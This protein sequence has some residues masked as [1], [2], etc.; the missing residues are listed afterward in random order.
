MRSGEATAPETPGSG[1]VAD[2]LDDTEVAVVLRHL[3]PEAANGSGDPGRMRDA[4]RAA[5]EERERAGEPELYPLSYNQ[6]SLWYMRQLAPTSAAYNVAAV[7]RL[8]A[9]LDV[10]ALARALQLVSDRHAAMRTRFITLEGRPFQEIHAHLETPLAIVSCEGLDDE[11]VSERL[12]ADYAR[13][14]ELERGPALKAVLYT[15]PGEKPVLSLVVHHALMDLWSIAVVLYDLGHLYGS[16][17]AGRPAEL[18]PVSASYPDFVR[19]QRE[20]MASDEAEQQAE[21]WEQRLAGMPPVLE[22]PTDRPRPPMPSQRGTPLRFEL[23]RELTTAIVKLARKQK[24]TTFVVLLAAFATLMQRYSGQDD[25]GIGTPTAGRG[26]ARFRDMAGHCVNMAVVRSDFGDDPSFAEHLARTR[27]AVA[28][29][30][31]YEDYPF[32]EVVGRLA[33]PPDPSRSP[34]FQVSF[35]FQVSPL[36]DLNGLAFNLDLGRPIAA[37]ELVLE[38]F[39]FFAQQGQFDLSLWTAKVAGKLHGEL[40]YSDD[41]FEEATAARMARHFETLLAGIVA[42][43]DRPLS[44]I[45]L[46][47]EAERALTVDAWNDTA[48]PQ[49]AD[50]AMHQL[51]EEQMERTP[52]AVAVASAERSLTYRELEERS[53]R[54]AHRLRSLGVERDS[55][56]A[57]F[58]DR[59]PDM[60]AA[61]LG[62]HKAGA[63]YV[64]LEPHYPPARVQFILSSLGI[65]VAVS[66]TARVEQLRS[67]GA[68]ALEHVVCPDDPGILDDQP[69]AR[70]EGGGAGPDTTAYIIFTS[71]STGTPKGVEV[72][73]RPVINLIDWVNRTRG[74]APGDRLLFITSLSFDLSVYDIF[75]SLAA[76]ATIRIASREEIQDP[77]TLIS[78][79]C[80]DGITIWDSAPPALNQLAPLLPASAP[81]NRLRLVMLSGDWIPVRLPDQIRAVFTDAKVLSLGGATEATIWSNYYDVGEVGADWVSIPYGKPIQN[82]RY[83]ILDRARNPCPIGV[84]GDL[85]IGGECLAAGYVNDPER[86]AERFV[87]DPFSPV[88]GARMYDTGDRA[89]FFADGNIEFLGRRDFQVKIRGFRI[90]LGEIESVLGDHPAIQD[91]SV[92]AREDGGREKY[93]AAY[94]V[95]AGEAPSN[96]DLRAHL[97]ERLPDFMV[98]QHFVTLETLPLTPNGKVDWRALPVPELKRDDLLTEFVEPDTDLERE[99]AEIWQRLIGIDRVGATD[100]FFELGGHSLLAVQVVHQ[101]EARTGVTLPVS[102]LLQFPTVRELAA[103]VERGGGAASAL[104]VLRAG[105]R[106]PPLILLHPAGGEVIAYRALSDLDP[107]RRLVAVQSLSRIGQPEPDSVD[108]MAGAYADLLADEIADGPVLLAGWSLGGVLAQATAARLEAAGHEV[109]LCALLDS[110]LPSDRPELMGRIDYRLGGAVGPL[111]G[112]LA[113]RAPEELTQLLELAPDELLGRAIDLAKQQG[114]PMAALPREALEREVAVAER[115]SRVLEAHRPT[116]IDA[117]IRLIWAGGSLFEGVPATDWAQYTRGG[118]D[119]IVLPGAQ[120]YTVLTPPHVEA[121]CAQLGRWIAA[122]GAR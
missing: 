113:G 101:L 35:I 77:H 116:A 82:A 84:P 93:L 4:L 19:W 95:A 18:D 42:D 13:P 121:V 118:A 67:L 91:C 7:A 27:N 74:V 43:P 90:E 94:L 2:A 112:A 109:A 32:S 76:G 78:I 80:D 60:I 119:S 104:V 9:D 48:R 15:R 22:L 100:N 79:L 75:G 122:A 59:S 14:L 72:K 108:A 105:E 88:P 31:A 52:D 12:Q 106:R 83:Y 10:D 86:T 29:V 16:E 64:P 96:A 55:L 33:P 115:H 8:D 46:L 40:K 17:R 111:A 98:P 5:L 57:V 54:I 92:I 65:G 56:V 73:H 89:R 70:P 87:P 69:S 20:F 38:P 61:V 49:R 24:T 71:G 114:D 30:M 103:T 66:E 44:Q 45:A 53:N 47:D 26:Q 37:G 68:E 63:G 34:I 62:I 41:L 11:G 28:D 81:G 21:F 85:F 97:K 25:L 107:G 23:D 99:L 39:P 6:T 36:I 102:V 3:Q 120:H 51:F 50:V 58:M 110:V 117:P 1:W